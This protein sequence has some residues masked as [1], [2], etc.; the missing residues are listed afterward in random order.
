MTPAVPNLRSIERVFK[1]VLLFLLRVAFRSRHIP[2]VNPDDFSRILVIRQHNQLGDMLCV[3][4]LLR[5]LRHRFPGAFI[6]L[7]TSPVNHEVMLHHTALDNVI[8]FD[9]RKFL[10]NHGFH[11][12][13][14]WRFVRQLRSSTFD[15]VLVP[16][17]VSTSVT[18]DLLAF[19]TGAR[20]R[21][22]AGSIDGKANP[23]AFFYTHERQLAWPEGIPR[24]QSERNLDIA[25]P[26]GLTSED[27][28]LNLT[29]TEK[30]KEWGRTQICDV[31]GGSF[32]T[33]A[34]H[35]GAGKKANRWPAERFAHIIN[36]LGHELGVPS[37]LISGPMD[38][39]PVQDV[40]SRLTVK[41]YIIT[42]Q[43]IRAVASCLSA[44]DLLVSNDTGIMHVGAATGTTVL[45][46][47]GPT[48]P[49]Q[50]APCGPKHR[51]IN[52]S[53]GDI[54]DI[55]T[56]VVLESIRRMLR[57]TGAAEIEGAP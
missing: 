30:E 15:L 44:V 17:T 20:V 56:G 39:T 2:P 10:D 6:A 19:F 32:P 57:S 11:P 36:T 23:S 13:V 8:V 49:H 29:L 33:I 21:I 43:S 42:K 52:S 50:W 38:E 45:S 55:P 4:P 41:H 24:H 12:V 3:T 35:V 5:T 51:Y 47:F 18:S 7:L 25:E 54:E 37:L 46:I 14:F 53:S 9:K 22:G 31:F 40:V 48:D 27:L 28:T 1:K 16:A 34:Y 26:L